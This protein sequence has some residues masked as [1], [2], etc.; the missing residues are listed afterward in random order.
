MPY[1]NPPLWKLGSS[2]LWNRE[3]GEAGGALDLKLVNGKLKYR[4]RI[5]MCLPIRALLSVSFL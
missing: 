5:P 2:E 1:H 4:P 3:N